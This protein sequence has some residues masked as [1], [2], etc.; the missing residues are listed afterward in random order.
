MQNETNAKSFITY[1]LQEK[2]EIMKR[3]SSAHTQI[4]R[5][6]E[7][8]KAILRERQEKKKVRQDE[9]EKTATAMVREATV[10]EEL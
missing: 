6:R 4:D 3:M 7:R 1:F 5:E 2:E 8:Q 10:M 9:N